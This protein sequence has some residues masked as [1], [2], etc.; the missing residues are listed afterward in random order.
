MII[1]G[2]ERNGRP[3]GFPT[4]KTKKRRGLEM[5]RLVAGSI[6]GAGKRM[7]NNIVV[8]SPNTGCHAYELACSQYTS[9]SASLLAV[10]SS[11]IGNRE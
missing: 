1:G 4:L 6:G 10:C 2:N 5:R 3:K 9:F 8:C 7:T 11:S